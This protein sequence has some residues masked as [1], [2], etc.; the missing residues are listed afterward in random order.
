MKRIVVNSKMF[1]TGMALMALSV[2]P[3]FAQN[4]IFNGYWELPGGDI[5]LVKERLYFLANTDG[6][7]T[8]AIGCFSYTG[9]QLALQNPNFG[10]IEQKISRHFATRTK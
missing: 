4:T 9:N 5:L 8:G 10:K 3:A 7:L 1:F 2:L 6:K